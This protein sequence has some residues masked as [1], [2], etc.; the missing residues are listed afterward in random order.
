MIA[1]LNIVLLG[2]V[3]SIIFYELTQVSPGGIIVP[4]I[5]ALYINQPQRIIFTIVV[6]LLA[7]L[8]IKLLS[9]HFIIFGR[10]RFVILIITS[11]LLSLVI[12]AIL[13][14]TSL[15]IIKL[16]IIG[17]TIPGLIANDFYKQGIKKTLPSL[18]IVTGLIALIMVIVRQ[19]G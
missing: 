12:S 7:Y 13:H 8:I 14:L 5:L 10:R 4:G 2:V 15:S 17:Y 18:I 19:I 9:R 16:T 6:A 3:I 1:N 11:V